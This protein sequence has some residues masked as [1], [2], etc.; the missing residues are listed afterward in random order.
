MV[1]SEGKK[2]AIQTYLLA[3]IRAYSLDWLRMSMAFENN[4]RFRHCLK[5]QGPRLFATIEAKVKALESDPNR[6]EEYELKLLVLERAR[7]IIANIPGR[8]KLRPDFSRNV[9]PKTRPPVN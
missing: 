2:R 7:E 3:G 6:R 5:C 9:K 4:R 1:R 8:L